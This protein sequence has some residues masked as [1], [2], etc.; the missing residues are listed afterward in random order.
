MGKKLKVGCARPTGGP[1]SESVETKTSE[2]PVIEKKEVT[3]M[4][5][6]G[7]KAPDFEAPGYHNG[8][9]VSVKLSEHLGKWVL[10]CF[11]PGDFTFV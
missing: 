6:V 2:Q 3:G 5:K 7:T 1:V 11:Y 10:L 9:F 4:I 8:E